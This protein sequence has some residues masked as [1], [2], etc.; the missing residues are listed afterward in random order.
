MS[1]LY[2]YE[3]RDLYDYKCRAETTNV[4][5]KKSR[6]VFS[7]CHDFLGFLGTPEFLDCLVSSRFHVFLGPL[8]SS[9]II[10]HVL[11]LPDSMIFSGYTRISRMSGLFPIFMFYS[12]SSVPP[13]FPHVPFFSDNMIFRDF[14]VP[15]NFFLC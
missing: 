7:G 8:G 5:R 15:P 6:P 2:D 10:F 14:Q 3:C 4:W 1:Q 12:D 13:K 9:E 11:L